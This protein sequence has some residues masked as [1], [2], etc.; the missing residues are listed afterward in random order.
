VQPP[1]SGVKRLG[2]RAVDDLEALL[3][4]P[5]DAD[6]RVQR[7]LQPRLV[8]PAG[9]PRVELHAPR[10]G[11][12][13]QQRDGA[14]RGAGLGLDPLAV[15]LAG[16]VALAAAHDRQDVVDHPDDVVQQRARHGVA[17]SALALHERRGMVDVGLEMVVVDRD[18]EA[19]GGHVL[20]QRDHPRVVHPAGAAVAVEVTGRVEVRQQGRRVGD[21]RRTRQ[22]GAVSAA[23]LHRLQARLQRGGILFGGGHAKR[24]GRYGRTRP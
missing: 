24:I 11:L 16:V 7:A 2:A 9:D 23:V 5:L 17:R 22:D 6:D 3:A 19:V 10:R 14:R 15:E 21:R 8:E 20:A 13:V 4:G 18:M 1:A 12:G